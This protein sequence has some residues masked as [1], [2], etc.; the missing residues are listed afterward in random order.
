MDELQKGRSKSPMEKMKKK[1]E[2]QNHEWR[3]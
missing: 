3:R 2:T 1:N